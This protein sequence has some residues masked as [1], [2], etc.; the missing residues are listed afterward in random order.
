VRDHAL[1]VLEFPR[2]LERI[3]ARCASGLGRE[4]VLARRPSLDRDEVMAALEEVAA[5]RDLHRAHPAWSPAAPPDARSALRRLVVE[6]S[7]L[8]PGDLL[9]ILRL[10]Q[11]GERVHEG[12][13]TCLS[14]KLR[15]HPM[16]HYLDQCPRFPGAIALLERALEEDGSVA[17]RAS[18]DLRTIRQ[19]IRGARGRIVRQLEAFVQTLPD[20]VRVPDASVSLREGRYVIQIRREGKTEVGG[21]IHGDSATGATLFVEP[22][23]AQALMRELQELLD[24]E[25]REIHRILRELTERLRP[26]AGRLQAMLL[27]LVALDSLWAR[28]LAAAQWG[29]H[30]PVMLS[31]EEGAAQEWVVVQARHPLLLD[32]AGTGE[33]TREVIP[34]SFELAP[35]ERALV[36][37][38]PNTGGKTVFL[39]AMG[40]LPLLAQA[41]ILPPVGE[42]TRLPMVRDVFADIG[43]GQSIAESLSTFSA[44]MA[45]SREILDEAAP[46]TLV[47]MDEMGTG[48]DPAEG[49]ALA[50][51]ILETLVAR[52]V[53]AI[54]TSHLGAL[55]RLDAEGTGIV[56]GSLL[57][58]SARIA[59]T[60]QFQKGRP[61]RS[62]GL[63]IAR[64]LGLPDDVLDRAETL[65]DGGELELE[66]LLAS[67]ETKEAELARALAKARASR[68][69]TET[70]KANWEARMRALERRER[71]AEKQARE[72]ARRLLLDARE[73]VE[74]AIRHL[75]DVDAEEREVAARTARARVEEAARRLREERAVATKRPRGRRSAHASGSHAP[76]ASRT[77][78]SPK[79]S[80][81]SLTSLV[82]APAE[83][84]VGQTVRLV[85][86]GTQGTVQALEE[87][88]GRVVVEVGG[89][90]LTVPMEA[91]EQVAGAGARSGRGDRSGAAAAA[92]AVVTLPQIFAL[93]EIH[94]LGL[95]VDE[96]ALALGRALDGAVMAQLP[97]LRIVH[98][99]GTGAL[100][101][102][103]H[104][105]LG[106][107]D[108]V[109]SFRGGVHGE[110]GAGV[111][112]AELQ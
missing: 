50:R 20:R 84:A 1:E 86:A 23:L 39:K 26:E 100:R 93:H 70:M 56:N 82:P 28:A 69:D 99:K 111:T 4:A 77:S 27:A 101:A 104:E 59:P 98:G 48:T 62:Y 95:R 68:A 8:E 32:L 43:D 75:R 45:R 31:P 41:G 14:A 107:D 110:G 83:F 21:A 106:S 55:K 92:V 52:G 87:E 9:L 66:T 64:R 108:R 13:S 112:I 105:I 6:G 12:L 53:R 102:R 46:G 72:D 30:L 49:A 36:L 3:G 96:V 2:V 22:P 80:Q 85:S 58:D 47:L 11:A 91:V 81:T 97:S 109:R 44:H 35:H 34:F 94:L 33:H 67:L 5:A 71:A 79:S 51:A 90:R 17:D 24:Q 57:F 38:G 29:A 15:P 103:V 7:V 61:G 16:V 65:V 74:A 25:N 73:E 10:L 18:P 76:Q 63:A 54:V 78:E 19:R 40:L 89:M 60:Y 37:S 88:R 42:G